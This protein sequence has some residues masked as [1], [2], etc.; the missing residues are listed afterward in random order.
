MSFILE[1]K[2][3]EKTTAAKNRIGR[4]PLKATPEGL[5]FTSYWLKV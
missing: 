2:E 4:R 3:G 5:S 1:L